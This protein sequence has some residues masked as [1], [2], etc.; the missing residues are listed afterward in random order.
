MKKKI[1]IC[2]GTSALTVMLLLNIKQ[3]LAD[4]PKPDCHDWCFHRDYDKCVLH[5]PNYDLI[6]HHMYWP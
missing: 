1:V 3:A 4:Y 2:L 5:S 6:C